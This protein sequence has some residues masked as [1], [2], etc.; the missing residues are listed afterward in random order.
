MSNSQ[1]K[2]FGRWHD[3]E[4]YEYIK[5]DLSKVLVISENHDVQ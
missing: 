4:V 5:I 2:L 3:K 1:E